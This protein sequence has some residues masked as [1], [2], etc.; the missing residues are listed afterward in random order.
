MK[1]I[2]IVALAAAATFITSC[3]IERMPYDKYTE[4]KI[5][6]DKD[7]AVDVL[8]NG[9]Y[10]KLKTASEHLHYCGEFPGDN[11]CKD[12]PTTNPFGTYF[13]YQHTVNNGGLS[14]VWNSAYNIISQTSSLMK[15]I[16]ENGGNMPG[17]IGIP[18]DQLR[19]AASMAVCKI[20]IDSDLR[21]P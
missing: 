7:A 14:T 19:K 8:L 1:K 4:D 16:N 5:M 2:A 17:A 10:A 6:E 21:L 9:C 20:N 15:M 3:D 13:T 11:V 18:E 12:K